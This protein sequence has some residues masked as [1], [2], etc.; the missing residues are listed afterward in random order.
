MD[1]IKHTTQWVE[2]EI[3]QG[4]IGL[5]IGVLIGIL[6]FTLSIFNKHLTKA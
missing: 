6:F 2:G 5:V 3:L 1:L 4:R